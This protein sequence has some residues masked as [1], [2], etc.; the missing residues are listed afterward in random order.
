VTRIGEI[1][2]LAITSNRRTLRR[3][4]NI[5]AVCALLLVAAKVPSSPILVTKMMDALSSSES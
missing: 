4:T 1:G 5:F 2:T 3:S